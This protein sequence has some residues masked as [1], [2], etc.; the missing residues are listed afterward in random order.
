[1]WVE[2]SYLKLKDLS[3]SGGL[4]SPCRQT[5]LTCVNGIGQGPDAEVSQENA[6]R[7]CSVS[8]DDGAILSSCIV[9]GL[10]FFSASYCASFLC[11]ALQLLVRGLCSQLDA[12]L[13]TSQHCKRMSHTISCHTWDKHMEDCNQRALRPN[14]TA[15]SNPPTEAIPSTFRTTCSSGFG[16]HHLPRRFQP[17]SHHLI[18]PNI[19]HS[20]LSKRRWDWSG[21][22]IPYNQASLTCTAW[23][24]ATNVTK[25]TW[26]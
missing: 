8:A 2:K 12:E 3:D 18:C 7:S 24:E 20:K 4:Y 11:C 1:M 17:F 5:R 10:N 22:Q 9:L 16:A 19:K 23:W 6:G 15:T 25:G 13:L 14:L 26:F 21:D